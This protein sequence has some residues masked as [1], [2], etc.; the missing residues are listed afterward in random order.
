MTK[1]L[2]EF[3]KKLGDLQEFGLSVPQVAG[4]IFFSSPIFATSEIFLYSFSSASVDILSD[5]GTLQDFAAHRLNNLNRSSKD[6]VITL[7]YLG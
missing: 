7:K 2:A 3:H 6:Y 4:N 5:L 1:G